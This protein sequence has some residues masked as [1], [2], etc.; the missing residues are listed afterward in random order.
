[1][2]IMEQIPPTSPAWETAH[3]MAKIEEPSM[4]FQMAKL[5]TVTRSKEGHQWVAMNGNDSVL[6]YMFQSL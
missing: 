5:R 6:F 2:T 1:M 4:V 3:G